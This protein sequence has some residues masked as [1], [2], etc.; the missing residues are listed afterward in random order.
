MT[1]EALLGKNK[2]QRAIPQYHLKLWLGGKGQVAR[3]PIGDF[4]S[5]WWYPVY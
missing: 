3:A 4:V 1:L 5:D 2:G